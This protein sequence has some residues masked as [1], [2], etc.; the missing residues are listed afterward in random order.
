MVDEW[1]MQPIWL[2]HMSVKS[3]FQLQKLKWKTIYE[4][5]VNTG[6]EE[7]GSGL[8]K[9]VLFEVYWNSEAIFTT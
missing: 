9:D 6:L 8:L 7:G 5:S 3:Q 1:S 2:S 4:W